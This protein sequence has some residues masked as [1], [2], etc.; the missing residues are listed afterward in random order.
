MLE[1]LEAIFERYKEVELLLS[2]PES[3]SDMKKFTQLN[4]EY[5]ELKDVAEAYHQYKSISEGM[6]EAKRI[7]DHD[8]DPEMRD[9]AKMELEDL[10]S[11]KGPLEERIKTLLLPK[12]PQDSKNAILEIR[13]GT[14]G[15]EASIFAGDLLRMYQRYCAIKGWQFEIVDY[16][17]GTAGGF[18]KVIANIT[19]NA[20][21][22]TMKFESGVHRV[23]RVPATESQGRV[24]TSAASVV[25]LPEAE[26]FDVDVKDSDIRVDTF[27]SSG[28]GG[29]SVNTTYSAVRLTHIPTGVVAQ[30]Q[31]EKS[32]IK[33]K[34][35]AMKVLR[36]RIYEIEYKKYL[37][38]VTSKRKTMV[39]TGD[40]SAKIRTYNYPQSRITD[41]RIGLTLYN[42]PEVMNGDLQEII[43]QLQFAENAEKMKAGGME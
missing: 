29:Q 9:M 1:K 12:D 2:S 33:N 43:D 23:Q 40:R 30:C 36:S 8:K 10:E 17:D 11:Q 31:D 4:K 5:V 32:Q 15:D 35:K 14:G 34:E 37:D 28:P 27:Q 21:Y 20:A 38:E 7:L 41:H 6:A 19:A 13:A 3:M 26:E 39:S 25:V 24:H 16:V 18:S 22:G 42:L